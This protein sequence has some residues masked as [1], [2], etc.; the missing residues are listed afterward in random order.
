MGNNATKQQY[1]NP[2]DRPKKNVHWKSA[3]LLNNHIYLDTKNETIF[4]AFSFWKRQNPSLNH[5][6][7]TRDK[8]STLLKLYF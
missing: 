7:Y 5:F 6:L 3:G 2:K 8:C 1:I 4:F